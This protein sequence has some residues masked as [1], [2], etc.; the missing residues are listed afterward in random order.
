MSIFPVLSVP[1]LS[2]NVCTSFLVKDIYPIYQIKSFFYI[3]RWLCTLNQFI[4][5]NFDPSSISSLAT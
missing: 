3:M 2:Y 1:L 5:V 4:F